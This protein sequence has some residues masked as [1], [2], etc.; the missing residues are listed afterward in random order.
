MIAFSE[1]PGDMRRMKAFW[2]LLGGTWYPIRRT[3]ELRFEHRTMPKPIVASARRR[4]TPR[5]LESAARK[6]ARS[7]DCNEE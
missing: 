1:P 4:D 6:I 5:K 2:L 3:G 7:R